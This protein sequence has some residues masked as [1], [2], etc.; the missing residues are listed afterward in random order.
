M[1][2]STSRLRAAVRSAWIMLTALTLAVLMVACTNGATGIAGES[3]G[4]LGDAQKK[5]IDTFVESAL[6]RYDVPGAAVAVIKDGK[7]AHQ[8]GFGVRD[9]NDRSPMTTSSLFN[10]ASVTKPMTTTMMAS[11][12]DDGILDW[13]QPAVQILPGFALSDPAWTPQVTVRHLAGMSSGLP[14]NPTPLFMQELPPTGIVRALPELGSLAAPGERYAYSN[15]GFSTGAFAAS[16]RAGATY[17]D[18]SLRT[19]YAR[20]MQERVFAPIGMSRATLDFDAA[21]ADPDH[22][23]PHRYEPSL[24]A[25]ETV[26]I[27]AE[28]FDVQVAPGGAVWSDVTDVAKFAITHFD[29]TALDG[30]RIVS[31]AG[32]REVHEPAV[33]MGPGAHYALGWEVWDDYL[34]V[35]SLRHTGNSLGFTTSVRL[36]QEGRIGVVVLAN[37]GFVDQFVASV[38]RFAMELLLGRPHAGDTDLLAEKTAQRDGLKE[39]SAQMTVPDRAEAEAYAGRYSHD[40]RVSMAEGGLQLHGDFGSYPLFSTGTPGTLAVGDVFTGI[41]VLQRD[42]DATGAT[43]LTIGRP[44]TDPLGWP[45]TLT[46]LGA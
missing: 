3:S 28:R 40:V 2:R 17:D 31:E 30:T 10:L 43:V 11:L 39:H 15:H 27:D 7:I 8:A 45:L 26:P 36:V 18:T 20:L 12:A 1:D 32:L 33:D 24:D 25:V 4:S 9:M 21:V 35:P 37:E 6:Q 22:V 19:T 13:N 46:R 34:G 41:Y 44:G 5:E 16:V 29:G 42:T 14:E 23:T 38:D